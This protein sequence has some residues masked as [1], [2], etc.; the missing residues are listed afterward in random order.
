MKLSNKRLGKF[1]SLRDHCSLHHTV[2]LVT[3][4][5]EGQDCGLAGPALLYTVTIVIV[6]KVSCQALLTSPHREKVS[7]EDTEN[8]Y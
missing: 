1:L 4:L 5:T 3:G 8:W 7:E 6:S 2:C